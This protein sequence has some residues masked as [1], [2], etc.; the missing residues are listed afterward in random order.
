MFAFRLKI[1]YFIHYKQ[2]LMHLN[3]LFTMQC[4]ATN[5]NI[6]KTDLSLYSKYRSHYHSSITRTNYEYLRIDQ[7]SILNDDS[8]RY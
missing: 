2:I 6:D 1:L 8:V 5:N 4:P 3:T 7:F